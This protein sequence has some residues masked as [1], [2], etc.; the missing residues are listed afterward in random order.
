MTVVTSTIGSGK[1]YATV[2]AW[3]AATDN[4]LVTATET[5]IGV[6]HDQVTETVTFDGATT[7]STYYRQLKLNLNAFIIQRIVRYH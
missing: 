2:A 7:D 3:E 5:H 4:D 1:D 6:L